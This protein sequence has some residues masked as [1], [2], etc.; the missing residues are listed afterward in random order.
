MANKTISQY[1]LIT[2]LSQRGYKMIVEDESGLY[3]S[4][5]PERV[6][7]LLEIRATITQA[8]LQAGNT[9]PIVI[10]SA[11]G[12]NTYIVPVPDSC[13]LFL[14]YNGVAYGGGATTARLHH[15]GQTNYMAQSTDQLIPTTADRREKLVVDVSTPVNST[16]FSNTDLVL[17]LNANATGAGGSLYC[18]FLL[19]I[20]R[21]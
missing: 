8:Q 2:N 9:T 15:S 16:M 1:T 7:G 4:I 10:L 20:I 14:D 17:S 6:S 19:R 12:N 11:L 21:F 13:G 5:D 3:K 18:S